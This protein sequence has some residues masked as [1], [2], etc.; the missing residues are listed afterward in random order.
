MLYRT[1]AIF[2]TQITYGH[3]RDVGSFFPHQIAL[4]EWVVKIANNK[5]HET[6]PK[7]ANM[8]TQN[9]HTNQSYQL[10]YKI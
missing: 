3:R 7:S 5:E 2:Y 8:R 1:A 10:G 9:N 4:P 6:S